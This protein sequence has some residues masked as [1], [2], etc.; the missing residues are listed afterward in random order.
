LSP[1]RIDHLL[2]LVPASAKREGGEKRSHKTHHPAN[3]F[4]LSDMKA[5]FPKK[6]VRALVHFKVAQRL[7]E[8]Q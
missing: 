8:E 4:P 7:A 6:A 3:S 5:T 2:A 1:E